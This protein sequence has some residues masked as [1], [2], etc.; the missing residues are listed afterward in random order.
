MKYLIIT[1]SLLAVLLS[2]CSPCSDCGDLT[3]E[4]VT[5]PDFKSIEN[6]QQ[7]KDAFFAYLY[8]LT[9]EAN[10]QV[11]EEKKL[12]K[13][14]SIQSNKLT[15]SQVDEIKSTAKLYKVKCA[16]PDKN[17]AIKIDTKI[18]VVPPSL[19][20]AQAANESAWG[21]SRFATDGSNYFGQWCYTEGC[22]IKPSQRD[23]GASHEV[24]EFDSPFDSVKGYIHNLN[25]SAAYKQL[26]QVRREAWSQSKK[27]DGVIMATGLIKYSERGAEYVSENQ[28]MIRY[29]KL[30]AFDALFW[31]E[32]KK[33]Q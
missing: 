12:L 3:S 28:H 5:P 16:T 14:W 31:E 29:N 25:T 20:L 6:T 30:L 22:G 27:P 9:L 10:R 11:L 2:G 17:C 15:D 21:T 18:G 24:K 8:P 23:T 4:Q 19:V 13:S 1:T 7:K 26:R 32:L 33:Y